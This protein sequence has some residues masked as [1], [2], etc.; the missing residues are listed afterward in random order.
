MPGLTPVRSSANV[1]IVHH[2]SAAHFLSATFPTLRRHEASANIVFAHALKLLGSEAALTGCHFTN[3]SDVS[4]WWKQETHPPSPMGS[5]VVADPTSG[6]TVSKATTTSG[7]NESFWLTV[8]SSPSPF[9]PPTLDI[10]LSCVSWTLGDY[11]IFLWTPKN[12]TLMSSSWLT[13]RVELL[14]EHLLD[15]V[16]PQRV[17][18]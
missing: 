16:P 14:A 12:P 15:M 8:W 2:G 7:N 18:S 6:T 13:S 3:E 17:F 10:V 9:V 4:T 5:H 1:L 11:P